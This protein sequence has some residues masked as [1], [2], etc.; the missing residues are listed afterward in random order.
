MKNK[1]IKNKVGL[2]LII[3]FS[4]I[5][6]LSLTLFSCQKETKNY[7]VTRT[8]FLHSVTCPDTAISSHTIQFALDNQTEDEIL[9]DINEHR[10]SKWIMPKDTIWL[11]KGMF[12]QKYYLKISYE[13]PDS[14]YE[15]SIENACP[16][17]CPTHW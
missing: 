13:Y 10:F 6:L 12:E 3:V 16:Y 1:I 17:Y 4:L 9:S 14:V 11:F 15:K 2:S 5:I 8:I 7:A